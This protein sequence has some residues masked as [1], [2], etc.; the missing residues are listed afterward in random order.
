MEVMFIGDRARFCG[1]A[2]ALP[3]A[4]IALEAV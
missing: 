3:P 4:E 1:V 2:L